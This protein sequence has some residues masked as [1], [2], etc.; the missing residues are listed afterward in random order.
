MNTSPSPF[1]RVLVIIP[2]YNEERTI[3]NVLKKV[4]A[5]KPGGI[6][7]VNDGST[8]RTGEIIKA[9]QAEQT[10]PDITIR[11]LHNPRNLGKGSALRSGIQLLKESEGIKI[12]IFHDADEEY[13]PEDWDEGVR[14]IEEGKADLV[15]GS[16]FLGKPRRVIYALHHLA[17]QFITF[18]ANLASDLDLSDIESGVK[19]IRRSLL[20][21]LSLESN[22]FRIEIE[23]VLRCASKGARIYEIPV[24]YHGRTYAEGKKIRA[25]DGLLALW[26][27]WKYRK[28]KSIRA[29]DGS[30]GR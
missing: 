23:I 10:D 15:V 30:E 19:I 5:K 16:R 3:L 17:N 28:R 21:S 11:V 14:L 27:I 24:S 26:A 8:D 29:R 18:L 20:D 6:I 1:A 22:D 13:D 4:I 25:K 2:A 12:V 7:I 9:W